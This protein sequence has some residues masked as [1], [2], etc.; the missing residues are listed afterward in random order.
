MSYW[1][2]RDVGFVGAA[3][4]VTQLFPVGCAAGVST[5]TYPPAAPGGLVRRACQGRYR[6]LDI[7]GDGVNSG[8]VELWDVAGLDRGASNNV[9]SGG[10]TMTDAY[11]TANGTL[12]AKRQIVGTGGTSFTEN[13]TDIPFSKGLAIRFVA[14]AGNISVSPDVEGGFMVQTVAG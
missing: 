11:V 3:G 5:T 8:T 13:D 6:K 7:T 2:A 10:I 12:I 9:N 14:A 1:G 4:V